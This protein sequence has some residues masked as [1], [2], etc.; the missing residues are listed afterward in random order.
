LKNFLI[1]EWEKARAAKRAV[2]A[3]LFSLNEQDA[4]GRYLMEPVDGLTPETDF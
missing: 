4:D 3:W 1:N 2:V